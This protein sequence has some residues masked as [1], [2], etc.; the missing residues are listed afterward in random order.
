MALEQIEQLSVLRLRLPFFNWHTP[1]LSH[2]VINGQYSSS[3]SRKR[4]TDSC[5][6]CSSAMAR[7]CHGYIGRID[8]HVRNSGSK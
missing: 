2:I 7:T 5:S 4:S 8:Q 1:L 6:I 3:G